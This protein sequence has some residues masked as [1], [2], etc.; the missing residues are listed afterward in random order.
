[1]K[2]LL[3]SLVTPANLPFARE[4]WTADAAA[5]LARV[6]VPVLVVIGRKDV[7][8]D[9]QADGEPLQRAAAGRENVSFLFPENANHVLKHEPR[10]RSALVQ[11]EVMP[12]Y[13][14]AGAHLDPETEFAIVAWIQAHQPPE[15]RP[16]T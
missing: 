13:N 6:S 4:L 12:G 10:P 3:Q 16:T 9:W 11:A 5:P 14:A 1:M 2:L 15:A 8:V 7:Q